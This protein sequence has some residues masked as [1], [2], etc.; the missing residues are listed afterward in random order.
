MYKYTY[1]GFHVFELLLFDL[2]TCFCSWF[3]SHKSTCTSIGTQIY[4][5]IL[6]MVIMHVEQN[7]KHAARETQM[8]REVEKTA[9]THN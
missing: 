8:V 4:F 1:F 5:R 7:A 9:Y 6:K 3:F 2:F